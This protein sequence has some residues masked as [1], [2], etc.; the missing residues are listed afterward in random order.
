MLDFITTVGIALAAAFY[1]W[2]GV[3]VLHDVSQWLPY[4]WRPLLAF[5]VFIGL[6]YL[7]AL[8]LSDKA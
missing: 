1:I 8:E 6:L 7:G 3:S 5:T 4:V 2:H